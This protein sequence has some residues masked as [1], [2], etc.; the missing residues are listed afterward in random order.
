M[1][2]KT[3]TYDVVTRYHLD[4]RRA[5]P[6]LVQMETQMRRTASASGE[7]DSG[8]RRLATLAV[9]AFGMQQA[10]KAL[11][12]YNSYM[13]QSRIQMAGLMA[14]AGN[15]DFVG[16]LD[17][18]ATLMRQMR[19]DSA[20]TV[21]TTQ[22]YVQMAQALV[23]PLT[24]A[25]GSVKDLREMTRL[26]VVASKAVGVP[27]E[28]G[29]LDVSQAIRG[30]YSVRDR[31]TGAILGPMGYG[32]EEG[33][34]KWNTQMTMQA[35]LAEL[36]KGFGAPAIESMA[37]RQ[38]T[39]WEGAFSTFQSK[40]SETLGAVGLPLFK[41]L[42]AELIRWND[43]LTKNEKRVGDI[44]AT[45]GDKLVRA[46]VSFKDA[47]AWASD[48]WKQILVTWGALKAAGYL[49]GGAGGLVGT[50]TGGAGGLV[51]STF[52]TK[53]A[54]ISLVASAVYIGGTALADFINEQH[55]AKIAR[56][57]TT[58]PDTMNAILNAAV[59][60]NNPMDFDSTARDYRLL[61][62]QLT[63]S[64]LASEAGG[65]NKDAFIQAMKESGASASRWADIL[66]I[67]G[68]GG[69]GS[70]GYTLEQISD[71]IA[72]AF[73]RVVPKW[74]MMDDVT[75][76]W[77]MPGG[78]DALATNA[79]KPKVNITINRI[80]VTS[81]DPD[82]WAFSFVDALGNMVKNPSGSLYAPRGG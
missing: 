79:E 47:I 39:T 25:G 7:L 54:S 60:V 5:T 37:G 65:L 24:M 71:A 34:H 32:G 51:G 82:R 73:E 48:H 46:A 6:A 68:T 52:G 62:Q 35:R 26:A 19:D 11:I 17:V 74:N 23:Q 42:T 78:K 72:S 16:N 57:M 61:K 4:D 38:E 59:G 76:A 10:S 56:M 58:G 67:K 3:T 50:A 36:K 9:G 14:Q 69:L 1:G 15:G 53:V 31:L 22:D 41:S 63:S 70:N 45:I 30:Q 33:R 21:G 12:G 40:V 29:A 77:R 80:E 49:A 75:G 66:G 28:V 8:M 64:G 20:K 43:W 55:E 44:T 81:E 2:D 18:A 27:L 13:E